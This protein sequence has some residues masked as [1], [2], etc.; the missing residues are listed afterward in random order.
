MLQLCPEALPRPPK[1]PQ[2]HVK[3]C[4]CPRPQLLTIS[5]DSHASMPVRITVTLHSHAMVVTSNRRNQGNGKELA[6]D[7]A[8]D[9]DLTKQEEEERL[10]RGE[11]REETGR[12]GGRTST[13]TP[14]RPPF[15]GSPHSQLFFLSS[16]FN[17]CNPCIIRGQIPSVSFCLS[18]CLPEICVICEICGSLFLFCFLSSSSRRMLSLH[19]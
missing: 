12:K 4:P 19:P 18:V 7:F 13:D 2:R 9:A 14:A 5:Q 8:D 3:Q 16:S 1:S 10:K 17:P 15:V 6:A 11:R